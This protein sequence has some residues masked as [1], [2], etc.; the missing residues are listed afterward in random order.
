MKI[1]SQTLISLLLIL[2]FI[3]AC[4]IKEILEDQRDYALIKAINSSKN[5]TDKDIDIEALEKHALAY[6]KN[7]EKGKFCLSNA[8]IGYKLY[9][10]S[11][12]DKSSGTAC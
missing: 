9:L 12:F 7:K 6:E 1:N 8:L 10:N 4:N 11:D 3:S 2:I 5:Q